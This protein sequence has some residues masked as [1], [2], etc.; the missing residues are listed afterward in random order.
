[1][2]YPDAID[3]RPVPGRQFLTKAIALARFAARSTLPRPLRRRLA[4]QIQGFSFWPPVGWVRFGNLRRVEPISR[5]FGLDRGQAIDRYYI[6]NFLA[7]HCADVRGSVLEVADDEYTRRFG[8]EGVTQSHVLYAH[9]GNPRAT[10]VADLSSGD[11]IQSNSFDCIILTQT[12]Q[13]IYDTRAA[14]QT[15]YHSL[16][17]GG[18]LLATFPGIGQIS[19]YDMDRWGDYWRF[20]TLSAQKL[21]EE[22]FLPGDVIVESCGNVLS[23]IS[24]L[25]GLAV[26]DV[27]EEELKHHDPDYEMLI[28]VRAIKPRE[29]S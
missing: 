5:V 10:I 14:I 16:K 12:L 17:P 20:T 19:R 11:S 22:A 28:T 27:R 6:E 9:E 8:G 1:M 7:R 29:H 21:F 24:L 13:Y 18:V 23:A 4:K 3:H 15:L 2:N 25:Q 26:E